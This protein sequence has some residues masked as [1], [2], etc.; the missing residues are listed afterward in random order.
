MLGQ[1]VFSFLINFK[2]D[3]YQLDPFKCYFVSPLRTQRL[4][5]F[6]VS[7]VCLALRL[8]FLSPGMPP[9]SACLGFPGRD[10][11]WVTSLHAFPVQPPIPCELPAL[12]CY[13]VPEIERPPYRV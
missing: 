5:R 6:S 3:F 8:P 1:Q 11:L 10:L 2:L 9:H 4:P 7:S 13:N 12:V